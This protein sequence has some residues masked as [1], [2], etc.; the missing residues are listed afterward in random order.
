MPKFVTEI[1][2]QTTEVTPDTGF[3]SLYTKGDRK[4]Y[5]KTSD[6]VEILLSVNPI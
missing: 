3:I 5:A 1:H 4:L 6:G 2:V